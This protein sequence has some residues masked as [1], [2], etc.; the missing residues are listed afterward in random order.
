ME[1]FK[2]V[3]D[4]M[5]PVEFSNAMNLIYGEGNWKAEDWRNSQA[6]ALYASGYET[7]MHTIAQ[8]AKWHEENAAHEARRIPFSLR[9]TFKAGALV[10]IP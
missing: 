10:K 8:P 9:Q 3:T 5:P 1:M 4:A 7:A 6:W 2:C